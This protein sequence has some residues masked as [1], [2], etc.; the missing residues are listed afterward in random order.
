M[1]ELGLLGL[2][3]PE[4]YDGSGG[5]YTGLV[6]ALEEMARVSGSLAITFD[7]HTS[8]CCEPI[9]LFGSEEQKYLVPLARGEKIGAFGLTEPQAGSDAGASRTYAVRDG[10]EWVINARR[11]SSPTAQSPT[12]WLSL[13]KPTRKKAHAVSPRSWSKKARPA[14][15]RAGMRKRWA[16]EAR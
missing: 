15:R 12:W 16:S 9:Y 2:P 7:A 6:I 10:D 4:E 11:S 14:F 13:P 8:L 5:D 3:F 1:G